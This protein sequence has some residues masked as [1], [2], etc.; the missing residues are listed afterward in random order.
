MVKTN[1]N[2]QRFESHPS[3]ILFLIL[4]TS[5]LQLTAQAAAGTWEQF[6]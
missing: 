1:K 4:T 5:L 3:K 6:T 2:S